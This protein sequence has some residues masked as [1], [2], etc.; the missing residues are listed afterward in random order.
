[1]LCGNTISGLLAG[2]RAEEDYIFLYDRGPVCRNTRQPLHLQD[3]S[4]APQPEALNEMPFSLWQA[5]LELHAG[6]LY[7]PFLGKWGTELFIFFLGLTSVIVLVTGLR[8]RGKSKP[9]PKHNQ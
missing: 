1:M 6:R 3:R 7:R 2:D 4:F 8:R 5:A 9:H